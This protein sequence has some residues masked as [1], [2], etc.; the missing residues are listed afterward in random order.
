MM[1]LPDELMVL[2]SPDVVSPDV[3][4]KFGAIQCVAL[5]QDDFASSF[6]G[7]MPDTLWS[8]LP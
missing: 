1:T 5:A 6:T 4:F 3:E 7:L 8:A 2:V